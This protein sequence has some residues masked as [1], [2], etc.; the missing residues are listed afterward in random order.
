[1]DVT[2][3][4]PNAARR[5][6]FF[7]T[8]SVGASGPLR[9]RCEHRVRRL[10]RRRRQWLQLTACGHRETLLAVTRQK[11]P[12]DSAEHNQ[13]DRVFD[14]AIEVK[15]KE[16]GREKEAERHE[17]GDKLPEPMLT[18]TLFLDPPL[19]RHVGMLDEWYEEHLRPL[20][21]ITRRRRSRP[22]AWSSGCVRVP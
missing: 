18:F 6:Q 16:L 20:G 21:G 2:R 8:P 10:D 4:A 17:R 11:Q 22:G 5:V 1:M 12:H 14:D 19:P 3:A 13:F 15:P 7:V 9:L